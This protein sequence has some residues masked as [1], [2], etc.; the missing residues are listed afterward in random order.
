MHFSIL[1]YSDI[2]QLFVQS[3]HL[4]VYPNFY[5]LVQILQLPLLVRIEAEFSVAFQQ[6]FVND[7]MYFLTHEMKILNGKE[8]NV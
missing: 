4:L 3:I 7:K 6:L 5:S 2:C 1:V 8:L